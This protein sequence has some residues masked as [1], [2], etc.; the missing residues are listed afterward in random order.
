[1]TKRSGHTVYVHVG[2]SR[3]KIKTMHAKEIKF[4]CGLCGYISAL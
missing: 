2:E 4:I 3:R 1:M